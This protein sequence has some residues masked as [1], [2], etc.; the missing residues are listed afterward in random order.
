MDERTKNIM[1]NMESNKLGLDDAFKF[2]CRMCGKCCIHR[3]D[4]ILTP[5]DIFNMSKE[6]GIKPEEL[7]DRYCEI[8]IGTSSRLPVIRIMPKG[9]VQRCPLL[10][11]RKCMVHKVKPGVCAM[12]PIGRG[13]KLEGKDIGSITTNDITYFFNGKDCGNDCEEHTV[14]EWLDEFGMSAE[15]EFFIFWQ[16]T[17][18]KL[19]N[20]FREM[21]R[22][23]DPQAMA[24]LWNITTY[25]LYIDYDTEKDFRPQY[26]RNFKKVIEIV[27]DVCKVL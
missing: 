1:S 15:D 9:N 27:N 23:V 24:M 13:L 8:Y 4:I 6:L 10:K 2:Q 25:S 20:N 14:R 17:I 26:E 21:E 11:D 12:Y 22:K 3:D 19:C 16:Q 7:V 18:V 5:R